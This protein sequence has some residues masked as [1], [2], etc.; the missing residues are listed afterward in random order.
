MSESINERIAK[1]R[2][3]AGYSQEQVANYLGI[4]SSTYSQRERLGNVTCD[5]LIK[6]AEFLNISPVVLLLGT[7]IEPFTEDE[8]FSLRLNHTEINH[9]R[10]L[11]MISKDEKKEILE[12]TYKK[13]KNR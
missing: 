5:F 4:K 3:F 7:D 8:E 13:F 11:R 9:I 1:Y 12:E 6:V 2:R 10:M